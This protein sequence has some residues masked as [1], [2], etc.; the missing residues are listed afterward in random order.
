MGRDSEVS[1]SGTETLLLVEDDVQ[2]L[3]LAQM[4]LSGCGYSVLAA[5]GPE[6][7]CLVCGQYPGKIDLLITDVIMPVM[8]GKQL[9][10]RIE[11]MRPGIKTLFMSGY[12]ADIIAKSGIIE[13]G[14]NFIDKPFTPLALAEKTRM[15]L[16]GIDGDPPQ[17]G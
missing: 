7:A 16:D 1:V 9:Q 3:K 8:N 13:Q 10:G 6:E 14:F 2:L 4:I 15:V 5:E 11:N 12:T 17:N